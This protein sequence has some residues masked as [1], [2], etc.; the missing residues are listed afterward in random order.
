M[1]YINQPDHR[2]LDRQQLRDILMQLARAHV[3]SSPAA[4]PRAEDMARLMRQC[5]SDLERHWL[6]F[7]EARGLRLPSKAQVFIEACGTRPD[8]LYEECQTRRLRGRTA[9]RVSGTA[10]A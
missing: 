3:E 4:L 2:L 10:A 6:A 5:Q 1:S 7:L 9:S 8:F